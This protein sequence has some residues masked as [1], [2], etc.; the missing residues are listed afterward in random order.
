MNS[1]RVVPRTPTA[2]GFPQRITLHRPPDTTR[3]RTQPGWACGE[4]SAHPLQALP[5]LLG[6][7]GFGAVHAELDANDSDPCFSVLRKTL[8]SQTPS[9]T[10]PFSLSLDG[11]WRCHRLPKLLGVPSPP[12]LFWG[13]SR[14]TW[15]L[16]LESSPFPLSFAGSTLTKQGSS[17]G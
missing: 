12:Q 7:G 17:C 2:S 13:R 11:G 1:R 8:P 14:V 4:R 15:R 6:G 16:C 3:P 10:A 5:G 9:R